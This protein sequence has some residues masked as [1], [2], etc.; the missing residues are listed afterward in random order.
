MKR[1]CVCVAALLSGCANSVNYSENQSAVP[2]EA[3]LNQLKCEL[4]MSFAGL[5]RSKIDFTGWYIDGKL[6]TNVARTNDFNASIGTAKLVP[7]GGGVNGG[8]SLGGQEVRSVS[9]KQVF[10][11]VVAP[12]ATTTAVC[13][14]RRAPDVQKVQNL[15]VYQWIHSLNNVNSGQPLMAATNLADTLTFGV[16][17]VG[18]AGAEVA[19]V[20]L[21]AKVDNVYTRDDSNEL[22]LTFSPGDAAKK[23]ASK[24]VASGSSQVIRPPNGGGVITPHGVDLGILD[25]DTTMTDI[26]SGAVQGKPAEG[27][28]R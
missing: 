12:V 17:R 20:A 15:G 14:Q 6:T 9:Q 28:N 1:M 22:T 27:A 3:I 25:T 23:A 26:R 21:D 24:S 11:F 5:D 18:K 10:D 19:V 16:K 7:L 8:F 2:L 4:A 13:D